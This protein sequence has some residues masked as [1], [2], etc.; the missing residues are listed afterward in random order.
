MGEI[1]HSIVTQL[2]RV[3][4]SR[5]SLFL[6]HRNTTSDMAS[7]EPPKNDKYAE[8]NA[9]RASNLQRKLMI[10]LLYAPL[11]PLSACP[12]RTNSKKKQ[13]KNNDVFRATLH[14]LAILLLY[15]YLYASLEKPKKTHPRPRSSPAARRCARGESPRTHRMGIHRMPTE[16]G[17]GFHALNDPLQFHFPHLTTGTNR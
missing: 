11:L 6:S 9:K 16:H 1:C 5:T 14:I 17:Y 4:S 12:S 3:P 15:Q 13:K 10:P 7:S 2:A 8:M